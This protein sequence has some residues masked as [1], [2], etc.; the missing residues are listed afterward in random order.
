MAAIKLLAKL[1]DQDIDPLLLALVSTIVRVSEI[2]YS[3]DSKRTPKSLLQLYNLTWYHRE[4]CCHFLSDPK[5]QSRTRLFGIYL[6][7]LVVHAPSIYSLVCMRSTNAESQERLFSQAKHIGLKATNRKPENVLPKILICMQARQNTGDCQRSIY[8]QDSMVSK[9]AS[10]LNPMPGTFISD[11]FISSRLSSWQAHLMR[12]SS[13]LKHGE[14]IWGKREEGGF[15]FL[16]G[17][18]DPD[19]QPVGPPL[20]HFRNTTLPDVYHK[21]SADWYAILHTK[22][23]QPSPSIRLYDSDGNYQETSSMSLLPSFSMEGSIPF[24]SDLQTNLNSEHQ[25][26]STLQPTPEQSHNTVSP[27]GTPQPTSVQTGAALS[28]PNILQPTSVQSQ[29]T[30]SPPNILQLTPEQSHNTVSPPGTL[31]PTSV[32][33]GA[34][35]SPSNMLQPTSVQSQATV[36]PP[37]MLPV[38]PVHSQATL[39]HSGILPTMSNT[40]PYNAIQNSILRPTI[41]LN[42]HNLLLRLIPLLKDVAHQIGKNQE[43]NLWQKRIF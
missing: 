19:A 8:Q 20:D 39:S 28:P 13:Y 35:L 5:L 42:T 16:D 21:R 37:G 31:Q 36:S 24:L 7:D 41:Y 4:L 30:V 11:T 6:H 32:Q 14:G 9:A 2:L 22:V 12:I 34:A 23:A 27:P 33:I 15:R 10:K 38:T 18:R 29:A 17:F 40:V 25:H 1:N 3:G 43:T 26:T